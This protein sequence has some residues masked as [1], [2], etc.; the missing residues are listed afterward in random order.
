[1]GFWEPIV[2]VSPK[3][4]VQ[5]YHNGSLKPTV[6][7]TFMPYNWQ[8]LQLGLSSPSQLLSIYQDITNI[9]PFLYCLDDLYDYSLF[10]LNSGPHHSGRVSEWYRIWIFTNL[11]LHKRRIPYSSSGLHLLFHKELLIVAGN[12]KKTTTGSWICDFFLNHTS[13]QT[14]RGTSS[15]GFLKH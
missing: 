4:C 12:C 7:G 5:W 15:L 10:I 3:F 13:F 6:L 11:L 1:M 2:W 8:M 14:K 9:E